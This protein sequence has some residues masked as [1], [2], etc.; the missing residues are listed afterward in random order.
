MKSDCEKD[1]KRLSEYLDG[2]LDE[3]A[4]RE[5]EQHLRE[6]PECRACVESMRKTIRLCKE[7]A[8]EEIPM[9]ARRRLHAMLQEC[10]SRSH[11]R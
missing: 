8:V 7:A 6:C 9:D 3:S 11:A 1:I 2:E 5:I 4:C 10:F